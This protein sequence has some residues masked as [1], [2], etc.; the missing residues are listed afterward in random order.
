MVAHPLTCRNMCCNCWEILCRNLTKQASLQ[1]CEKSRNWGII[2]SEFFSFFSVILQESSEVVIIL[3]YTGD[4]IF[5]NLHPH[6][7]LAEAFG[8]FAFCCA[9]YFIVIVHRIGAK[10]INEGGEVDV[11]TGCRLTSDVSVCL[12]CVQE[13]SRHSETRRCLHC[14]GCPMTDC[15]QHLVFPG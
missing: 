7:S 2:M 11:D 4:C 8:Q 5:W 15:A 1:C 14:A 9:S 3:L 12:H 10:A 13:Y 6:T